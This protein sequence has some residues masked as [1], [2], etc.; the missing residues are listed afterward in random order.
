VQIG[1]PS[2]W[3]LAVRTLGAL[4]TLTAHP[5]ATEARLTQM[6]LFNL[7][8]AF[9]GGFTLQ[10]PFLEIVWHVRGVQIVARRFH[11][12]KVCT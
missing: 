8:L 12:L 9:G 1:M 2:K 7:T 6:G 5:T 3:L 10:M 4:L 11:E